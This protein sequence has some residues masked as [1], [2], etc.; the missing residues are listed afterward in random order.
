MARLD[1]LRF[2]AYLTL[3]SLVVH[4]QATEVTRENKD[5]H[6]FHHSW[7]D[8]LL[9]KQVKETRSLLCIKGTI[10]PSGSQNKITI[11][12]RNDV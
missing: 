12:S 11:H 7:V 2:F 5:Y 3:P 8:H 10:A 9:S 4:V 1:T 6:M